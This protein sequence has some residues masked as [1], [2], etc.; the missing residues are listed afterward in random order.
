M[1]NSMYHKHSDGLD[2]RT[3]LMWTQEPDLCICLQNS[4]VVIQTKWTL[5]SLFGSAH[6]KHIYVWYLFV[7]INDFL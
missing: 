4:Y 2:G 1:R 7:T 6:G 5:Y 3:V